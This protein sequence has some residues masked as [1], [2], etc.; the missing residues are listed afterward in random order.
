MAC[1]SGA[2]GTGSKAGQT[3]VATCPA[4]CLQELGSRRFGAAPIETL[5]TRHLCAA[6]LR[7]CLQPMCSS[8]VDK[9]D[10]PCNDPWTGQAPDQLGSRPARYTAFSVITICSPQGA[11]MATLLCAWPLH[12]AVCRDGGGTTAA[13]HLA[14]PWTHHSLQGPSRPHCLFRPD[15]WGRPAAAGG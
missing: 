9:G 4:D 3:S 15:C 14:S 11:C 6:C 12:H 1:T 2:P 10:L 5:H 7:G 13:V 8:G